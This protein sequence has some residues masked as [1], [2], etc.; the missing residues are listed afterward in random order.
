MSTV[1]SL[2]SDN[3]LRS[4]HDRLALGLSTRRSIDAVRTGAYASF[5]LFICSG[6]AAK[7][8]YDR[9]GPHPPRVFKGPPVYFYL[10]L[11]ATVVCLALAG[12]C[13]ARARRQM[14]FEDQE[15]ARFRD[16]R[17]RLGLDP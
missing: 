6:L 12:R 3:D 1:P 11:A 13:F 17:R 7:L 5:G 10:A 4:E 15:F 9:W 8:A 14:R 16:L 2:D